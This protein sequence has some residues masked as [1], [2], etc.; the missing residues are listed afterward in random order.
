MDSGCEAAKYCYN[1]TLTIN[2]T[3]KHGYLGG[4]GEWYLAWQNKSAINT[5]LYEIGS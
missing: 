3:T 5:A 4:C 1:N 2:G